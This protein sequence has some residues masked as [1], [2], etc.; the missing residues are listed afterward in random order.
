MGAGGRAELGV[1]VCDWELRFT[2]ELFREFIAQVIPQTTNRA[3]KLDIIPLVMRRVL[4]MGGRGRWAQHVSVFG[5]I[6]GRDEEH[7]VNNIGVNM[8][9]ISRPYL[10]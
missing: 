10:A 1:G 4:H 5:D 6:A 9:D 8:T 2:W 7:A 3:Q